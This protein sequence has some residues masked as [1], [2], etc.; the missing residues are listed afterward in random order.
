MAAGLEN[1]A[2][3]F[4]SEFVVR[5]VAQS[6][7]YGKDVEFIL[8]VWEIKCVCDEGL[9]DTT[10]R[11]MLEHF[12]TEIRG[13][14]ITGGNLL[15]DLQGEI[16]SAASDIE[17]ILR[18]E[19]LNPICDNVSPPKVHTSG[20]DV[21]GHYIAIRDSSEGVSDIDGIWHWSSAG[22]ISASNLL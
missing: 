19:F 11:S 22:G 9:F 18:R 8:G 20:E 12:R 1:T 2:H 7:S 17:E 6:E 14:D 13:N 4:Q 3:F 5:H 21:V 10:R 16:S 15:L